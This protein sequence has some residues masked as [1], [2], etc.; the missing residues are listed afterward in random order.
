MTSQATAG[1]D[2][3]IAIHPPSR[4]PGLDRLARYRRPAVSATFI[5]HVP[6]C[7]NK[8]LVRSFVRRDMGPLAPG[9]LVRKAANSN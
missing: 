7:R 2:K 9:D 4:L 8:T 5:A 3:I 1:L 6:T